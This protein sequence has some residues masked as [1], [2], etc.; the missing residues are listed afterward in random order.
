VTL[1]AVDLTSESGSLAVR[2]DGRTVLEHS[3]ES[4]TGFAHLLFPALGKILSEAE[5]TLPEIDCF[6]A[7]TGPG[8]FTGLRVALAGVKGLAEVMGKPALG[9]SKL[10]VMAR[11]GTAK[12]RIVLLDARR[13]EVYAAAYNEWLEPTVEETVT[14]LPDWFALLPQGDS[15]QF[16]TADK[17]WLASVIATSGFESADRIETPRNL[18]GAVALCAEADL[19]AGGAGDPS[20]LDANYVRRSDA[21]LYWTDN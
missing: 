1:L 6:A 17:G 11:F 8:A 13:G 4:R 12:Q 2:R 5:I 7:T 16:I 20:A 15:H 3:L 10:K 18:A 21:E 19:K 14:R 9:V